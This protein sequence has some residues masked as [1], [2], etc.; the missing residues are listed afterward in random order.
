MQTFEVKCGH[1]SQVFTVQL[2]EALVAQFLVKTNKSG[3]KTECVK[4]GELNTRT[5][6]HMRAKLT[7][8]SQFV[9]NGAKEYI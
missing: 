3:F 5:A 8:V 4:C 7:P 2:T 1:C 9:L 6:E